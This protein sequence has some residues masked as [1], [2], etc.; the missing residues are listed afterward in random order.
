MKFTLSPALFAAAAASL[1]WAGQQVLFKFVVTELTFFDVVGY[2]ALGFGTGGLILLVLFPAIRRSFLT[3]LK[4]MR[5][6]AIV[7]IFL[8]E[9]WST[10]AK[11]VAF[12]AI[13]LGPVAI[14][15]VLGSASV[16]FGVLLGWL[17]T[18]TLPRLF[19][20][21]ISPRALIRKGA[22]AALMFGGLLLVR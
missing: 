18:V 1:L 11:L 21:D 19:F 20:E 13:S 5:R 16:F 6:R 22:L 2:E 12:L 17:L 7:I 9:T 10:V 3:S 15:S 14:V 4:T 8:N